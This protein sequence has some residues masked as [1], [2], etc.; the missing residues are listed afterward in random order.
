MHREATVSPITK[1]KRRPV[2]WYMDHWYVKNSAVMNFTAK[3]MEAF[4]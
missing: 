3:I 2:F 1:F 4:W